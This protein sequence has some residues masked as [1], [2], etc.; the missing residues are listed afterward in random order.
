[1]TFGALG[2]ELASILRSLNRSRFS[3]W[4]KR[5]EE[6]VVCWLWKKLVCDFL[7]VFCMMVRRIG[8]DD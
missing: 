5:L 1:M 2:G 4:L 7:C 3:G 8:A 6:E